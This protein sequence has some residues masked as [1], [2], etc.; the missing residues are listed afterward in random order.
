[1]LVLFLLKMST[2]VGPVTAA[3]VYTCWS[4]F[5]CKCLHV[6]VLLLPEMSTHVGPVSTANV[7]L[8]WFCY[9]CKCQKLLVL[10]LLSSC[11]GPG[12][13]SNVRMCW[14][15]SCRKCLHEFVSSYCKCLLVLVLYILQ[16]PICVP[17]ANVFMYWSVLAAIVYTCLSCSYFKCLHVRYC[18]YHNC[19]PISFKA[20]KF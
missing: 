14:S 20:T 2:C 6:L 7:C 10:L 19:S 5:Y 12:P 16:M 4:G 15:Y 3:N 17:A 13:T 11:D 9:Y 8:C 1:M 18:S